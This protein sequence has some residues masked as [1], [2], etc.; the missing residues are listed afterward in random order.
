MTGCEN[1]TA[2][3]E[4]SG[5]KS[6]VVGHDSDHEVG[7]FDIGCLAIDDPGHWRARDP[8]SHA[9]EENEDEQREEHSTEPAHALTLM[10]GTN[11]LLC[12]ST[13]T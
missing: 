5:A 1:P 7:E 4:C 8:R 9:N 10:E 2:I 3:D 13:N 6:I 12:A 11:A